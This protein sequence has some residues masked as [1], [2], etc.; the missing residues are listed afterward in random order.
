MADTPTLRDISMSIEYRLWQLMYNAGWYVS[1]NAAPLVAD[2]RTGAPA[3]SYCIQDTGFGLKPWVFFDA[4]TVNSR[5]D[6]ITIYSNGNPANPGTYSL[7]FLNGR[8]SFNNPTTA[9]ISADLYFFPFNVRKGY[10]KETAATQLLQQSELPI[11]A[12]ETTGFGGPPCDLRSTARDNR[13]PLTVYLMCRNDG[14]RMDMGHDI[15]RGLTTVQIF[16]MRSQW[17]L[18]PTG[19]NNLNFNAGVQTQGWLRVGRDPEYRAINPV[20]NASTKQ[21]FQGMVSTEFRCAY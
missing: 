21:M 10:P 3:N 15:S 17:I 4:N 16:D 8:V 13:I 11:I 12:Y 20:V 9:T 7:D 1:V 6:H 2:T 18:T 14:E 19:N 5:P